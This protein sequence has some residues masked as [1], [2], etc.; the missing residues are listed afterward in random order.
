MGD[1]EEDTLEDNKL[2]NKYLEQIDEI[3]EEDNEKTFST[4]QTN[5]KEEHLDESFRNNKFLD[6]WIKRT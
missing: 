6:R 3:K 2:K 5:D 4:V 1:F